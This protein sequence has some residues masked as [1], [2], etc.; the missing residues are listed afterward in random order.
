MNDST[1]FDSASYSEQ[2]GSKTFGGEVIS[3]GFQRMSSRSGGKLS[4]KSKNSR[5][6]NK[7]RKNKKSRKIKRTKKQ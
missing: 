3:T 6:T 4:R 1:G 7:K 5:K 2:Y